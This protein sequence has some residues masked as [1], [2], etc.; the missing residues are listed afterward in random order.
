[1]GYAPGWSGLGEDLP[2]GVFTQWVKWVNSNRYMFDDPALKALENF[3]KYQGALRALC[4]SDDPWATR[5]AVELLCS[6]FTSIKPE[7]VTI[8][9]GD[10][11]AAKIGH[12]GFFRP[13]HR[14]TLWRGAAEWLQAN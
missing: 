2:E 8:T 9:P 12:F 4:I 7:I 1:M 13:E 14:D 3:P 11:K 5:P 6:A 10:A